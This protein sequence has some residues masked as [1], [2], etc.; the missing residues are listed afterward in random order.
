MSKVTVFLAIVLF[1]GSPF[2][3]SPA[4]QL[5]SFD[6]SS[7]NARPEAFIPPA[8]QL[9]PSADAGGEMSIT[10]NVT[11]TFMPQDEN[12]SC[13]VMFIYNPT[14]SN[15]TIKIL[16]Y[17]LT[18]VLQLNTSFVIPK[19]TMLRICS[20]TVT[21]VSATW[22]N[23]LV[24]NFTTFVTHAKITYPNT[25]KITAYVAWNDTGIYDPLETG[26]PTLP[27]NFY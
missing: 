5:S 24:I 18:D 2:A 14:S 26:V 19:K 13:T 3:S 23:V 9:T 21:S 16:G 8:Y 1:F 17:S 27:L 6:D 10:A 15:A 11:K 25:C 12:T 4:G 20:D 22:Q 7:P